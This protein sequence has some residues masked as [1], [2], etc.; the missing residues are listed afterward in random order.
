MEAEGCEY[1][2]YDGS[3]VEGDGNCRAEEYY[4]GDGGLDYVYLPNVDTRR[5][6][7]DG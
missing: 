6:A 3:N 7:E 1:Y 4:E 2:K 5:L